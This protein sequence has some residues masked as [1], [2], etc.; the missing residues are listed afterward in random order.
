MAAKFPV[1]TRLTKLFDG[2]K[3]AGKVV[4][5]DASSRWYM[6]EYDDGDK[7]ELTTAELTKLAARTKTKAKPKG[8]ATSKRKRQT[9]ADD[10]SPRQRTCASAAAGSPATEPALELSRAD[11]TSKEVKVAAADWVR[12][13]QSQ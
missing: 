12:A 2:A 6:V 4:S 1:G 9:S 11:A 5:Y 8:P 10:T 3:Y 13:L 7:E